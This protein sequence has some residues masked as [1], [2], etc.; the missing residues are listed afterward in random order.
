LKIANQIKEL[1]MIWNIGPATRNQMVLQNVR[2]WSSPKITDSFLKQFISSDYQRSIILSMIRINKNNNNDSNNINYVF[3][4][5]CEIPLL[6]KSNDI[7]EYLQNVIRNTNTKNTIVYDGFIDIETLVDVFS[8]SNNRNDSLCYLIGIYYNK[9][10]FSSKHKKYQQSM[11]YYPLVSKNITNIG[12]KQLLQQFIQFLKMG[13][14][15]R[16][17]VWRM[18]YYSQF[19]KSMIDKTQHSPK[20]LWHYH[21]MGI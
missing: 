17:V 7:S 5:T 9:H 21:R 11:Q 16:H 12:E 6:W 20:R 18:Y 19:E 8:I 1:T 15:D 3:D 10:L 4:S 13:E 14:I 2:S